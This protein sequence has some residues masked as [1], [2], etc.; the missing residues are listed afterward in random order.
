M[1]I[2]ASHI[3]ATIFFVICRKDTCSQATLDIK[4]HQRA[5][6]KSMD[7][8]NALL[9]NCDVRLNEVA[10][11]FERW[12]DRLEDWSNSIEGQY[13]YLTSVIGVPVMLMFIVPL[14]SDPGEREIG[15]MKTETT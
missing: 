10:E 11:L 6:L 7:A 2:A 9:Q 4:S 5:S 1:L 15:K 12:C 3:Y 8:L 14:V 13:P